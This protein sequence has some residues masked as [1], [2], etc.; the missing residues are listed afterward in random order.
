MTCRTKDKQQRAGADIGAGEAAIDS[1]RCDLAALSVQHTKA[2]DDSVIGPPAESS[3]DQ[4]IQ[5]TFPESGD[6]ATGTQ[7]VPPSSAPSSRNTALH[8]RQPVQHQT[9][10]ASCYV[11]TTPYHADIAPTTKDPLT[12]PP[13]AKEVQF[14][15][16]E[17]QSW[18]QDEATVFAASSS[19]SSTHLGLMLPTDTRLCHSTAETCTGIKPK[20]SSPPQGPTMFTSA[21]DAARKQAAADYDK[22]HHAFNE[23]RDTPP[24]APDPCSPHLDEDEDDDYEDYG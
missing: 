7:V 9:E 17:P 16:S 12:Q 13:R 22:S 24:A 11:E 5:R 3:M 4:P 2:D 20:E 21:A 19:P 23:T 15:V 1:D 18:P 10:D 14:I 8:N 6:V